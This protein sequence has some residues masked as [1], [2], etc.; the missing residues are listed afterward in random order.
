MSDSAEK[1]DKYLQKYTMKDFLQS[2][3]Q[4]LEKAGLPLAKLSEEKQTKQNNEFQV[5]FIK[6]KK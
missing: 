3:N 6:K 2:L 5:I 1:T 4:K